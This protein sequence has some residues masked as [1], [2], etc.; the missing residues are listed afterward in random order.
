MR[1]WKLTWSL[2][3]SLRALDCTAAAFYWSIGLEFGS[4]E[5]WEGFHRGEQRETRRKWWGRWSSL[6]LH[7]AIPVLY[8]CSASP[9]SFLRRKQ[10]EI[11]TTHMIKKKEKSYSGAKKYLA[12]P[13][14]AI[15]PT[16][17]IKD[18]CERQNVK[19]KKKYRKSHCGAQKQRL[20][21]VTQYVVMD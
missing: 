4:V 1:W 6:R 19:I 8:T 10:S 21:L 5:M 15:C 14:P 12:A 9:L 11:Q 18:N 17:R 3:P 20:L 7:L 16:C 2:S 13:D